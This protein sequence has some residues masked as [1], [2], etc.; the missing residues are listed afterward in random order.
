MKSLFESENALNWV[1]EMELKA[2]LSNK[3]LGF[4]TPLDRFD[5]LLVPSMIK[6]NFKIDDVCRIRFDLVNKTIVL[7]HKQSVPEGWAC[8][9]SAEGERDITD[10]FNEVFFS[11]LS[12]NWVIVG[13]KRKVGSLFVDERNNCTH[14]MFEVNGEWFLEIERLCE[15]VGQALNQQE[16]FRAFCEKEFEKLGGVIDSERFVDKVAKK[17][18]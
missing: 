18:A 4:T 14:E 10:N 6:D 5:I 11:L 16:E 1:F 15:N 12:R 3:P 7:G 17:G 9:I 2:K 13:S 8:Q